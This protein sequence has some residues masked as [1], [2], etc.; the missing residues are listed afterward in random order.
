MS[1]YFTKLNNISKG[2]KTPKKIRRD[3]PFDHFDL[4]SLLPTELAISQEV[5]LVD[6]ILTIKHLVGKYERYYCDSNTKNI[7]RDIIT[8]KPDGRVIVRSPKGLFSGI[9]EY[10]LNSVLNIQISTFND[11][12]FREQISCYVGRYEHGQ[13]SCL[14]CLTLSANANNIP[15]CR[16]EVLIPVFDGLSA[17]E[18]FVPETLNFFKL[19]KKYPEL[20]KY[21]VL[22]TMQSLNRV[23]W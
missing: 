21:I 20:W 19:E 11:F 12:P 16:Y 9:G 3:M 13:I 2:I 1:N 8:I 17:P 23:E 15:Y 18:I 10:T 7:I 14:Y 6:D 22:R 5:G 4:D